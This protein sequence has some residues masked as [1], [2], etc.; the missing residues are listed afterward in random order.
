MNNK[1]KIS[2][3]SCNNEILREIKK[4]LFEFVGERI[5]FD[6]FTKILDRDNCFYKRN[7]LWVQKRS[8]FKK[9]GGLKDEKYMTLDEFLDFL[10]YLTNSKMRL[11][12]EKFLKALIYCM[13]IGY[14]LYE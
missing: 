3:I 4:L 9:T 2:V 5:T 14:Y 8:F 6:Q 10:N 7:T 1:N 12:L 13:E 11:G